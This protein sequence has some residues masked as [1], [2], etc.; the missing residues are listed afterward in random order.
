M[1][2]ELGQNKNA[3]QFIDIILTLSDSYSCL[4]RWAMTG[5][6]IIEIKALH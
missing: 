1:A 4:Q 6:H 2:K 5:A 3:V